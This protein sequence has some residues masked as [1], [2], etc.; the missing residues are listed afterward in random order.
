MIKPVIFMHCHLENFSSFII[1]IRLEED[2]RLLIHCFCWLVWFAIDQ[3]K[4]INVNNLFQF[5]LMM[6]P[7]S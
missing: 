6:V 7:V 4:L 1:D 2:L 3:Y 5:G